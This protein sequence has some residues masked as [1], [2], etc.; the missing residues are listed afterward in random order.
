M[1]KFS[2][3]LGFAIKQRRQIIGM[4]QQ[5]LASAVGV[6]FQQIQ[7]YESGANR[8]SAD[9]LCVICNKLQTTFEELVGA[10]PIEGTV[11]TYVV[12]MVRRVSKLSKRDQRIVAGVI[13]R[14]EDDE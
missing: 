10:E 1:I 14:M 9:R 13:S 11:D 6:T 12:R 8:V 7:K 2:K 3:D 5:E 4:S